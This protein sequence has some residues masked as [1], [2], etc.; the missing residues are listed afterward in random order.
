[1]YPCYTDREPVAL[2]RLSLELEMMCMDQQVFVSNTGTQAGSHFV[3][4]PGHV[5]P[6]AAGA[7]DVGPADP[8]ERVSV[9][10]VLRRRSPEQ[11]EATIESLQ[12]LP[13][14]QRRHLTH[15]EFAVRHGADAQDIEKVR[16]FAD[17]HGLV[18][19]KVHLAA[20]TAL[21][22]GRVADVNQAFRIDLRTYQH[23]GF[24][25]RGH[26]GDVHVPM[27]IADVVTA[28]LGLDTRPQAVP[29]FRIRRQPE[30]AAA[31]RATATEQVAY[32]PPQVAAAYAFPE[33]VDCTGQCIGIIELGGGYSDQSIGE[34]FASLG[35]APPPLV[36]VG[37]DGAVNQP[38]GD[39][40]GP[41]G[42]V[43]L[44]IEV[45][46]AVAPGAKLAVYFAPNTDAGFLNAIATA[47]HDT[48]NKPTVIS[49]SWGGPENGWAAASIQAMNRAL[50]DAAALGV[51]VCV[52]AGDSGSTDGENDGLYHVDFPA[53]SPYALACGGT[54]LV[55]ENGQ[56]ASETVWNDGAQGGSTGG[57]VSSVFA[58]PSWQKNAQVPPS[59][60]PG[61]TVGRGVPDVAGDA[62]P[63][64]GYEVLVDGETAAIGGT[65]AVAPLWAGL[66]TIANKTIGQ[67]VGYL[68]PVLYSLPKAAQAFRDITQGNN[69]IAGT[70]D[71][72]AAGP[73]WDPCTGLG[74]PIANRLIAALQQQGGGQA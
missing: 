36:A 22:T 42:E 35:M 63:A 2:S 33:N 20:G 66:V 41:D 21:L 58:L 65:S 48:T 28:V 17:A 39:P 55:V 71:V 45:A 23:P 60:N 19:E 74:S 1:M 38:T 52:A 4:L 46:G 57:G 15:D 12:S 13:P 24:S 9:T 43:E 27:D 69:D 7:T 14:S 40:N 72:Y 54:R 31:M 53:S 25:Y 11:L 64:T 32:T 16:A 6:L 10:L 56:I 47:I 59:A 62:D 44:D 8:D 61:G 30:G 37:V 68:N 70:G 34:Y 18:L 3:P 5:R 26:S 49:I 50:Q 73:G 67:P 29:H 51:T